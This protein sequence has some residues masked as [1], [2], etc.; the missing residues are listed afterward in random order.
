M[1]GIKTVVR[2][3]G[4][5]DYV[6]GTL[7]HILGLGLLADDE[8]CEKDKRFSPDVRYDHHSTCE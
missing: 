8:C 1:K 5:S 6:S 4:S 3:S 2:V 7:R